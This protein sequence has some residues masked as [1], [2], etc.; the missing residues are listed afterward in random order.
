MRT[1]SICNNMLLEMGALSVH[2]VSWFAMHAIMINGT[3][4][5]TTIMCSHEPR[6]VVMSSSEKAKFSCL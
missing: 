2:V 5:S 1:F 4:D 3:T 6:D